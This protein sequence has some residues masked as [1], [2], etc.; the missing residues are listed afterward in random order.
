M[1]FMKEKLKKIFT[2]K[3]IS[4]FLN[5]LLF[6]S[7]VLF[8][9]NVFSIN[10]L[11]IKYAAEFLIIFVLIN[12][13]FVLVDLKFY[14]KKALII[15]LDIVCI[16]LMALFIFGTLKIVETNSFFN[17][18]SSEKVEI[19]NYYVV[20]RK[21]S[22]YDKIYDIRKKDV[23]VLNN[24]IN[25]GQIISKLNDKVSVNINNETDLL[26]MGNKLLNNSISV[27]LVSDA[28]YSL[29][30][31]NIEGFSNSTKKLYTI[32][33]E[34]KLKDISKDA[35]VTKESFNIY[36]SG[37]DTY[38]KISTKSRSDVNIIMTVNPVD[39][40]ILLTSIPRDYYVR[41]H[42]T[43]GYKDKLT[44][45]GVY[46]INMSVQTIEDLLNTDINYYLRVNFN[47]LIDVVDE[48]G[49]I[50][51]NSDKSFTAWTNRSCKIKSGYQTLDGKCALAFA[52]ERYSYNTGDRHRG[53]NQQ[54]VITAIINK[55]TSS[56]KIITNYSD[57][58]NALDGSFQTSLSTDE[59][60]AI[61]KMQIS[62]MAK[63]E[64]ES[65]SLNGFDSSNYT[66]SYGGQK[67]YVMEPDMNTVNKAKEKIYEIME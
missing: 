64:V 42:G 58:L 50:E 66:Y 19:T 53:E 45:A 28:N 41:L 27:I 1:M 15:I 39:K 25:Y 38:G 44:H 49:G 22:D 30:E 29:L 32:S 17:R 46:G 3:N 52:R 7:L 5:V 60:Y 6:I 14:K 9:V 62:D 35:K 36:I 8:F 11:P 20:V 48:L 33:L 43:T 24:E 2:L 65:I 16:L 37:I 56:K 31:E 18:N 59:I 26:E 40:K 34:S 67:L 23:Y 54:Q 10:I 55:A 47:T 61:I 21:N 4:L 63:W 12:M 57:I 13:I 51:I